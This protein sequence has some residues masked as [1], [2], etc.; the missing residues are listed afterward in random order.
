M[1]GWIVFRY[2][3]PFPLDFLQGGEMVNAV[4]GTNGRRIK[5]QQHTGH[6]VFVEHGEYLI[7]QPNGRL[8][9]GRRYDEAGAA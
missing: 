5:I 6:A 9:T 7:R 2:M 4:G 8:V 3:G 1:N